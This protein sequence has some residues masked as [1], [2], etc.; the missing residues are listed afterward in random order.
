[1][2]VETRAVAKKK[3]YVETIMIHVVQ[4]EQV[5]LSKESLH[6]D[7]IL[8]TNKATLKHSFHEMIAISNKYLD[9][10]SKQQ[11]EEERREIMPS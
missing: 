3:I 4:S 8:A 11:L 10:R 2:F 9:D 1:M 7:R 5:V 6:E